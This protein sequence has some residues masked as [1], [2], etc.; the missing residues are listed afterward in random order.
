MSVFKIKNHTHQPMFNQLHVC[1]INYK[2][3]SEPEASLIT[4]YRQ[5]DPHSEES[6]EVDWPFSTSFRLS[7]IAL[8]R[9]LPCQKN[10]DH[11]V[12]DDM[13]KY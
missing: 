9:T 11:D 1:S 2:V 3:S 13:T 4:H 10:C 12:L 8:G 7:N 6:S 5:P